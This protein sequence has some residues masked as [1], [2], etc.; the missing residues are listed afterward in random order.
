MYRIMWSMANGKS[1][2]GE[3]CLTLEEGQA[4]IESMTKKYPDMKHWLDERV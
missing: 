2:H 3:Y 1:G 4:L